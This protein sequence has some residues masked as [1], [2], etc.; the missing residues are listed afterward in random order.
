MRDTCNG[1]METHHGQRVEMA[2]RIWR[3]AKVGVVGGR[4][5]VEGGI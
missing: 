5:S 4:V 3:K 1:N 2:E